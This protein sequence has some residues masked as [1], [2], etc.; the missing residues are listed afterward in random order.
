M[1]WSLKLEREH[2]PSSPATGC[3]DLL[4]SM[5]NV[6]WKAFLIDSGCF[7]AE[8][9]SVYSLSHMSSTSL[10][11]GSLLSVIVH[12]LVN[13]LVSADSLMSLT[14]LNSKCCSLHIQLLF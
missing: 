13:H 5:A 10:L 9:S 4:K 2:F 6:K 11:F 7:L 3:A 12:Y 8:V 1:I 14:F